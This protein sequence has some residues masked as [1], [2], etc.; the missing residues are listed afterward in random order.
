MTLKTIYCFLN[1]LCLDYNHSSPWK[2]HQLNLKL[3]SKTLQNQW[4]VS[5]NCNTSTR[6]STMY[7]Y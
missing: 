6:A 2:P 4:R 3:V 1:H 5:F 7:T